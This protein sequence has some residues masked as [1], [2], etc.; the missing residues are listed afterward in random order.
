MR[1]MKD[2]LI[3]WIHNIAHGIAFIF[4]M[5]AIFLIIGI[6]MAGFCAVFTCAWDYSSNPESCDY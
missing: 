5:L 4:M 1:T 6:F 2:T 3:T